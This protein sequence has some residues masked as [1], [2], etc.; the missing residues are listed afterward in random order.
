MFHQNGAT[1]PKTEYHVLEDLNPL[2][3][4]IVRNGFHVVPICY[5]EILCY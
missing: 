2:S 1:H 5:M 3:V 4:L